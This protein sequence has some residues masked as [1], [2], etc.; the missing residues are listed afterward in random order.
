MGKG[1]KIEHMALNVAD[2]VAMAAWYEE[3]LGFSVVRHIEG[4]AQTHFLADNSGSMLIEIY[5]NP[6]EQVPNYDRMDPLQLH[7]AV[8]SNDP[9]GDAERIGIIGRGQP[10]ADIE[11][12]IGAEAHRPLRPRDQLPSHVIARL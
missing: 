1:F 9:A 2:P 10:V 11:S 7:L 12:G 4:P 5:N 6:P 3:H 8:V